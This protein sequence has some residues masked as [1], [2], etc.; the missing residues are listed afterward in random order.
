[1]PFFWT[2]WMAGHGSIAGN[3]VLESRFGITNTHRF[4]YPG[5]AE[6]LTGEA[7]D[8]VIDSNDNRRYAFPTV[9]DVLKRRGGRP[10][11]AHDHAGREGRDRGDPTTGQ[12]GEREHRH[13]PGGNDFD[14]PHDPIGEPGLGSIAR[15]PIHHRQ[16]LAIE[17]GQPTAILAR[18]EMDPHFGTQRFSVKRVEVIS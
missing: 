18:L 16:H 5:Y 4:S 9:L 11:D 6:I 8:A 15:Q 12:L 10:G 7:H 14:S 17:H 1:M 2:E 3:R 13:R